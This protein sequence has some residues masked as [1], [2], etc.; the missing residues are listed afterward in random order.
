MFDYLVLDTEGTDYLY[1]IAIIN[2]EGRL[3]YEAYAQEHPKTSPTCLKLKPLREILQE[4][5]TI[6]TG[7][8][9]VCHSAAHDR[10]VIENSYRF[11][12]LPIP[13]FTYI[14]T[15]ELAK[16]K[17]PA[18]SDYSL[19][20]L[21]K[22]FNLKINN[23]RFNPAQ[24]HSARYDAQFT[25][26]L[27]LKLQLPMIN[28]FD[29]S[30]VD[31]PFQSHPDFHNIY[32]QE[33]RYLKSVL[34]NIQTDSNHQSRGAVIIGP[35]GSGKT[36]LIMRMAQELLATN[37][38]LFI[39]Q[40]NNAQTVLYHIY[41]RILESF[42]EKVPNTKHTQLELLIA[43][44]FTNIL[45]NNPKFMATKKGQDIINNLKNNQLSLYQR[46][47]Q[48]GTEQYR[49]RWQTVGNQITEWWSNTYANAGNS[50]NILKG[51]IS[52]CK[53]TDPT[54][55]ELARRWLAAQ[56]L[57]PEAAASIGL[58]NWQEEMSREEF[59]LEA[60]AIFGKLSVLD[61]PLIIVFDQ[62][63][64]LGLIN[65]APIL[66]SF[67]AAVK[68]LLTHV[69][70]SL[71]ILNLF[72]D[73]WQQFQALLDPSVIDRISQH[74]IRLNRP[75]RD[76]LKQMLQYRAGQISLDQLF[77]PIELNDIL[78]Q[79][80]IRAILNRASAYFRYKY[81]NIPLPETTSH[82]RE[83]QLE[84]VLS[85]IFQI[86]QPFFADSHKSN[87]SLELHPSPLAIEPVRTKEITQSPPQEKTSIAEYLESKK[88]E[89]EMNYEKP[90]II[91]DANDIGKLSVILTAYNV[92]FDNLRLGKRKLPELLLIPSK[93]QVVAF[94]N[95]SGSSFTS[96]IKNF[97]ELTIN[98][99]Q[100][101]FL[102]LRD[103]R[104]PDITGRVGREEIAKLNHTKNGK[105]EMLQKNDRL[106][107]ELIYD[108]IVAI[109]NQ[110][111][112]IELPIALHTL[113]N[114][115]HSEWLLRLL[116]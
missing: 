110:D 41:S 30:R 88:S 72:P 25:H 28:P 106:E 114:Q 49:T 9:L 2:S 70:N 64:G 93:N 68:E 40:P 111:L 24:A 45:S 74:E 19:E 26:Q 73:R 77:T 21:S 36:H 100:Y 109:Q 79:K 115:L 15:Y 14:C 76:Q 50:I 12:K 116:T 53:F 81:E 5:T 71:I 56:E 102:L 17:F 97:N 87:T 39:R 59:A 107:L 10:E 63:E 101:Q 89:L 31:N 8:T 94:L 69:P 29:S 13:K 105:F 11:A 67:G 47:G 54:K 27:Y 37:R 85:Q 75:S 96:L 32:D 22:H 43:N 103:Q 34:Q 84:S 57:E 46:L 51:I 92:Q 38:L 61:S 18:L 99:P 58:T 44:S 112:E 80:S 23:R 82:S 104:E 52:F 95:K 90:T 86:L 16:Q 98:Y 6:A 66:E 91:D 7:K 1:E 60:I 65:N 3:V 33:Y 78:N 83:E 108:T 48:D 113:T 55:R 20:N 4:L 42:A 35:A 62:L